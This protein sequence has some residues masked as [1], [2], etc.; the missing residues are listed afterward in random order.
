MGQHLVV[1]LSVA[2]AGEAE[3]RAQEDILAA[4]ALVTLE[5]EALLDTPVVQALAILDQV[6]LL[7]IQAVP[8]LQV[9]KDI[10][11]VQVLV[12]LVVLVQ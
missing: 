11:V 12:T 3:R 4:R 7:V 2:G 9:A 1:W 6:V 10:L 5:L 8:A